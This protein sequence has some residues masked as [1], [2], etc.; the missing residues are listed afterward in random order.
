MPTK[1]LLA[2]LDAAPGREAALE[3]FLG[4]A[5]AQ[6]QS[7]DGTEAWFALKLGRGEYAIFDA[8]PDDLAR[9]RHLGGT[10]TAALAQRTAGLLSMPP[11][12]QRA[13]ILA[14]KLP[15][16][17]TR[18]SKAL[19]LTFRAK[20][21]HEQEVAEFLRGA[22]SLVEAEPKTTAW[23]AIRFESWAGGHEEFGIFDVFPDSGARF[24]HLTGHVP[25][26]LARHSLSLL[27]SVP[28]IGLVNVLAAKLH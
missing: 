21:G 9:D 11:L 23:F 2:R 15:A 10:L 24:S 19:L 5:L 25:R 7:E 8:F 28:E 3:E 27:G 22:R 18:V 20:L 14:D 1:A 13:D 6:A 16:M 17:R 26:E 12:I 4:S